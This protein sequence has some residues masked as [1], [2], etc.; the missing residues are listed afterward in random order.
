MDTNY[1]SDW[2]SDEESTLEEHTG[3]I[4]SQGNTHT[5]ISDTNQIATKSW[6][7]S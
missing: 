7:G 6:K 5:E 4:R 1:G 2:Q 3:S